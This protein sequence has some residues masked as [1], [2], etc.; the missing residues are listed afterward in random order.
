MY[1]VYLALSRQTV[2]PGA[3]TVTNAMIVDNAINSEHYTDASIDLAHMS[4]NSIDSDQYVDGSIDLAHMSADSVDSSQYVDA[5]IDN[6]HLADDAVGVDVLSA[7]GTAS[8][9]TFL[10]GDNAWAAPGGITEGTAVSPTSG[11]SI[12]FTSLPAGLKRVTFSGFDITSSTGAASYV[13]ASTGGAFDA[14][15]YLGATFMI[16]GTT[17]NTTASTVG[18]FAMRDPA[19]AD[20]IVNFHAIFTKVEDATDVWEISVITSQHTPTVRV[21][22]TASKVDLGGELDGVQFILSG[23]DLDAGTFNVAYEQEKLCLE[24]I[25]LLILAVA[26]KK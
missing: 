24:R 10:R 21:C 17:P 26:S 9:S 6:A 18:A 8:S 23:G 3:D 22:V 13:R 15:N 11:V 12:S 20:Y 14:T 7:T 25:Q 4:V 16:A 19:H 1:I 2:T 5:S